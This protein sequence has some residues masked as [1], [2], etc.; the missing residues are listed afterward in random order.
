MDRCKAGALPLSY[1]PTVKISV[2]SADG[3]V[4]EI[5]VGRHQLL[6]AVTQLSGIMLTPSLI[7][8][9]LSLSLLYRRRPPDLATVEGKA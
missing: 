9:P 7:K 5:I 1:T 2:G 4:N 6:A 3:I 8:Y